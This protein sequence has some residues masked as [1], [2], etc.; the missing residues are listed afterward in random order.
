MV[1]F[2]HMA[3]PPD[4]LGI[5]LLFRE[6]WSSQIGQPPPVP[7]W[8]YVLGSITVSRP[9]EISTRTVQEHLQCSFDLLPIPSIAGCECGDRVLIFHANN[10][11]MVEPQLDGERKRPNC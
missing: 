9:Q 7:P 4:K 2:L 11:R 10:G 5:L 8:I 6:K 3:V 1:R